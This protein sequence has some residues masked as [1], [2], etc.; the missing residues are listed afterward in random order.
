MI[1][2]V[3]LPELFTEFLIEKNGTGYK[4]AAK[5]LYN[6][7]LPTAHHVYMLLN[8]SVLNSLVIDGVK[9]NITLQLVEGHI[10]KQYTHGILKITDVHPVN[11]NDFS[12]TLVDVGGVK[13]HDACNKYIQE[14]GPLKVGDVISLPSGKP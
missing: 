14:N 8:D 2:Y 5:D 1:R 6:G 4:D 7:T 11:N 12:E 13:V 10:S 3:I 9:G